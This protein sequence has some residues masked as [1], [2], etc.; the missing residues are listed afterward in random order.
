MDIEERNNLVIENTKL[1]Y[2]AMKQMNLK[3]QTEDEWQSYY[4]FGMD[5][6]IKASRDFEFDK[7]FK[8]T[9]FAIACIRHMLLRKI[10]LN[11]MKKRFN[12]NGRD[13][14]LNYIVDEEENDEFGD[15]IEDLNVNIEQEIEKK[16][17]IERLLNAVENLENEKDKLVVKMYYGL[18]GYSERSLEIVGNAM[19][20]SRQMIRQRL[21]R[22][23]RNLKK[24]LQK[25]DREVFALKKR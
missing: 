9:T 20:C 13:L 11:T 16:L 7:G 19:G 18:D 3:W 17:E 15:F 25:N 14:S 22:A 12:P 4:D 23:K 6:L 2:L 21:E 1:I 24:S 8:F 5:G 10:Y